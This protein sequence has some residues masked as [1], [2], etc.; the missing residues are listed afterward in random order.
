MILTS[1]FSVDTL[2]VSQAK[3]SEIRE[4]KLKDMELTVLVG[5]VL[6]GWL[7]NKKQ[8]KPRISHN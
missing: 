6:C 4:E 1:V 3:L 5:I 8:I 2:P 7:D